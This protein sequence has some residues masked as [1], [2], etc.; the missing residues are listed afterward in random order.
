[1]DSLYSRGGRRCSHG[2]LQP[3]PATFNVSVSIVNQALQ[4]FSTE[5]FVRVYR[6]K[7]K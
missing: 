7:V 5:D 1:M 3:T 6:N 4:K 2:G